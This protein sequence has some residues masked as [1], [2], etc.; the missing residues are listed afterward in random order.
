MAKIP[1]VVYVM[2]PRNSRNAAQAAIRQVKAGVGGAT[3]EAYEISGG[4]YEWRCHLHV[5]FKS[6]QDLR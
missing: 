4:P 2:G 6:R 3:C 5:G 1:L